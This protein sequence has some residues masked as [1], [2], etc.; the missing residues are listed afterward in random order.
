MPSYLW[1]MTSPPPVLA[2][3]RLVM[4]RPYACFTSM[5]I[6]NLPTTHASPW[7]RDLSAHPATHPWLLVTWPFSSFSFFKAYS[8]QGWATE[9]RNWRRNG[10]INDGMAMSAKEWWNQRQNGEI[11]D[12]ME[13]LATV[14]LN[15]WRFGESLLA[16]V[17]FLCIGN[18]MEISATV[19]WSQWRFGESLSV[20]VWWELIGDGLVRDYQRRFGE[21]LSAW[22]ATA[23]RERELTEKLKRS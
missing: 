11:S 16:T 5:Y 7:S 17:G 18:G 9:W 3:Y 12:G 4:S 13:I 20:T 15:R 21:C 23:P 22:C 2:G 14:W 19:W 6:W 8:F 10:K 1:P